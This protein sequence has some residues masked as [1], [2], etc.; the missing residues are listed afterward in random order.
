VR[1]R[2]DVTFLLYLPHEDTIAYFDDIPG[3]RREVYVD[4][5]LRY[6]DDPLVTMPHFAIYCN[7]SMEESVEP[8]FLVY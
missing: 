5:T 1:R 8:Y 6:R 3:F 4:S 2:R 7:Y